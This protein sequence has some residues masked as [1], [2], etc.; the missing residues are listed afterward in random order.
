MEIHQKISMPH[1]QYIENDGKE[2]Y[3]SE[4]AIT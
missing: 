2:K 4:T 3:R 1:Y